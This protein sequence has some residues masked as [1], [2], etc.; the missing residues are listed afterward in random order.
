MLD[1][2]VVGAGPSG[3]TLALELKRRGVSVRLIEKALTPPA[4][5]SRAL[6]VQARTLEIFSFLGLAEE[7]H[8]HAKTNGAVNILLSNG[9]AARIELKAVEE[10]KTPFPEMLM[11]PQDQ[12]EDIL[13]ARLAKEGVLPERGVELMSL[14]QQ[15]DFVR[16]QLST[17]TSLEARWVVGCDGAHSTVRAAAGI[18]FDGETYNDHC[19]LGEL[20][21]EWELPESELILSPNRQGVLAAFPVPGQHRYRVICILPEAHPGGRE[22]LSLEEF[23]HVMRELVPVP[24][25]ITKSHVLSRYQLHHRVASKFRAG[26]VFLA[27]DAAHIHS[28]AGGQGMNTG[29]QDA[30]N[31]GW[32]LAA[33][34]QGKMTDAQLD[35]YEAERRP[36]ALRL[37]GFT[38]RLFGVMAGHGTGGRVLRL[39]APRLA[40]RAFRFPTVQRTLFAFLSQLRV[41]YHEGPLVHQV[42]HAPKGVATAGERAPDVE[43]MFEGR[44]VK[45]FSQLGTKHVVLA[46]R[47]G[48]P[49]AE[50][51]EAAKKRDAVLVTAAADSEGPV[52]R[53]GRRRCS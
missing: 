49:M 30:W 23:E 21:I 7:A 32:K 53:S 50:L 43:V 8:R 9:R 33:V 1:V 11:L 3:L 17:D 42:G 12:T 15:P 31:L 34:A 41:R 19:L 46:V 18:S 14:E 44:P 24:F 37:V 28:P 2:L 29:I 20:E 5:H 22:A 39:L 38:D 45:L 36:V 16:C 35:S 25:K 51:Q 10:L 48:L 13:R 27:G 26:R 52:A 4:D 40:S 47:D 6:A